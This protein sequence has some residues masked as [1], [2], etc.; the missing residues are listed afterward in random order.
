MDGV[1]APSDSPAIT[2]IHLSQA[3][4]TCQVAHAHTGDKDLA[5]N[6]LVKTAHMFRKNLHFYRRITASCNAEERFVIKAVEH[7]KMSRLSTSIRW[8]K[9]SHPH[10]KNG[11]HVWPM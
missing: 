1:K 8:I 10:G 2:L 3:A 7:T 4:K 6:I 9:T 5:D 11:E